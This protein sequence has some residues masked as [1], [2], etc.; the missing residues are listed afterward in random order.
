MKVI[1][2]SV[3]FILFSS[4]STIISQEP[5]TADQT[6]KVLLDQMVARLNQQPGWDEP[7]TAIEAGRQGLRR[8]PD[9][10]ALEQLLNGSWPQI[11]GNINT[12]ATSGVSKAILFV[13]CQSLRPNEYLQF[14]D[15]A[16]GLAEQKAI[17]KRLLRWGLFP[18]DKNVAGVLDYDYDKPIAKDVLQRVKVLYAD[19]R[20]MVNYCNATISGE[21]KRKVEQYFKDNPSEPR[22]DPAL[23]RNAAASP[24]STPTK[25]STP[26][27]TST[28]N[29][30]A[31][32]TGSPQLATPVAQTPA[33]T[34]ERKSPIWPWLV[35]IAALL[36]IVALALKRRA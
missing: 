20:D 33:V 29:P 36:V 3:L 7:A 28:P 32:P 10:V 2:A 27:R 14:L 19:D 31:M 30:V 34:V 22:P 5:K 1:F 25:P 9:F 15:Q 35:G 16:V 11:V 17:D 26:A 21:T 18:A 24:S 23:D 8:M 4:V 12:V 6:A 13:A